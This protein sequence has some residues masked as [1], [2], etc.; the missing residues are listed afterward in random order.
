MCPV[1][2]GDINKF[3]LNQIMFT[4]FIVL[5]I[6]RLGQTILHYILGTF[7]IGLRQMGK[8]IIFLSS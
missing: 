3:Y 4:Y 5:I 8:H 1:N 6:K 7:S 2:F